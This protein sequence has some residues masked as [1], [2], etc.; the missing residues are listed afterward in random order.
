MDA[1]IRTLDAMYPDAECELYYQN[2]FQLLVAVVLSAQATDIGVNKVTHILFKKIRTP[3]DLD[4]F[5]LSELEQAIKSIGLYKTKAK[6]LKQL[7]RLL[8]ENY[9][10]NVPDC[11]EELIKLP[12][13]GR[14]TANVVLS[15]A[16]N[17][18]A[19][20]VDTHVSRVSKRLKIADVDDDV[21][22]VEKKLTK[23]FPKKQWGKLHQQMILFGRYHC[24]A[25]NPNC[26]SC[27]LQYSCRYVEEVNKDE[28]I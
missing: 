6:N 16:F 28:N 5:S 8:I 7:A 20:A 10:S 13:V 9:Q 24:K 27:Q 4:A 12:G 3:E 22:E 17:I 15:V 14:K 11:F 18:P 21:L 26:T 19:F 2:A 1:I 23:T 25:R